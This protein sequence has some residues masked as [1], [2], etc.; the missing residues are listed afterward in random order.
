ME[1]AELENM[2]NKI[3]RKRAEIPDIT[4]ESP[5]MFLMIAVS[6]MS[7][8]SKIF[9]DQ[10][11]M[12]EQLIGGFIT[13][14]NIVTQQAFSDQDAIEGIRHQEF[15]LLLKYLGSTRILCVYVFKGQTYFA[16][17][18]LKTFIETV[19]Y[20]E[21]M[22]LIDEANDIGQII[23]EEPALVEIVT[24]IFQETDEQS[25]Q[26]AKRNFFSQK[27]SSTINLGLIIDNVSLF[28]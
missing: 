3:I 6:G 7:I 24:K 22:S 13:A 21:A 15:T 5:F 4:E 27:I 25:L 20:S 12:D 17:Q 19:Q 8:F 9:V 26:L 23:S 16:M 28:T 18:K 1:L 2:V 14:I 10:D 11:L